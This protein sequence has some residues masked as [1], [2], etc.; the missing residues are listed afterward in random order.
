MC[1]LV[2]E[3]LILRTYEIWVFSDVVVPVP[4]EQILYINCGAGPKKSVF[5]ICLFQH[6]RKKHTNLQNEHEIGKNCSNS[7]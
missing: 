7:N 1:L 2:E 6:E 3:M 4:D 5:C